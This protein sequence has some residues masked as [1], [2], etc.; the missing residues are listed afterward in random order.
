MFSHPWTDQ[1]KE[2]GTYQG[3]DVSVPSAL[4][5]VRLLNNH[6]VERSRLLLQQAKG[7]IG[8]GGKGDGGGEAEHGSCDFNI[9]LINRMDPVEDRPDLKLEPTFGQ[10]RWGLGGGGNSAERCH[11]W[12]C[13]CRRC[14]GFAFML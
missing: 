5:Q 2:A 11:W 13:C 8:A 9:A 1:A 4:R 12:C 7:G 10:D 3:T 14:C 6:L